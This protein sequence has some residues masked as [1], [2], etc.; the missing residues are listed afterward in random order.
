MD[1]FAHKISL[2]TKKL[3][4]SFQD[5]LKD[6]PGSV[7]LISGRWVRDTLSGLT[8]PHDIDMIMFSSHIE[9]F[10]KGL[11]ER[12]LIH[13]NKKNFV[14][15]IKCDVYMINLLNFEI[16]IRGVSQTYKDVKSLI[17]S[18]IITRDFTINSIYYDVIKSEIIDLCGGMKDIKDKV[19]RCTK[20]IATTF[21]SQQLS[22]FP[23]LIRL[24]VEHDL[25]LDENIKN[26]LKNPIWSKVRS[27]QLKCCQTDFKKFLKSDSVVKIFEKV[28]EYNIHLLLENRNTESVRAELFETLKL[29]KQTM[30]FSK[31][32]K[33]KKVYFLAY[34]FRFAYKKFEDQADFW[35]SMFRI[36]TFPKNSIE[37]H[38]AYW[39]KTI[40][41]LANPSKEIELFVKMI[42]ERYKEVPSKHQVNYVVYML[43][44]LQC[45]VKGL[46]DEKNFGEVVDSNLLPL[47]TVDPG[48]ITSLIKEKINE[49]LVKN[50]SEMLLKLIEMMQCFTAKKLSFSEKSVES[51]IDTILLSCKELKSKI[52]NFDN[53]N[54]EY[55]T[56]L[57]SIVN[58]SIE[59]RWRIL[60]DCL[61][62]AAETKPL[63]SE[64]T[65]IS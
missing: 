59:D 6:I 23:R 2:E 10:I 49:I 24:M 8:V 20:D 65:S 33:T 55:L 28:F 18:D 37:N 52:V 43:A 34:C 42:L 16:D 56:K 47:L 5:I 7:C 27:S 4:S 54:E 1:D 45:K 9:L 61:K 21:N 41:K 17:E 51:L 36:Q 11:E 22:R 14:N 60:V 48:N 38:D 58:P 26:Y 57:K 40:A 32:I 64:K 53:L 44:Y 62:I 31:F 46:S 39:S 13:K 15:Q 63:S 12:Y 3:L 25:V 50:D 29:A 35:H 19:L 30:N